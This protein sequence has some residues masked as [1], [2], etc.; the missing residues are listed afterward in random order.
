ML[1]R[2]FAENFRI[3]S[4][5]TLEKFAEEA[6]IVIR[7]VESRPLTNPDE[8][9]PQCRVAGVGLDADLGARSKTR[10]PPFRKPISR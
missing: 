10:P 3:A 4:P 5:E 1:F 7:S 6:L 8:R 9:S 2:E